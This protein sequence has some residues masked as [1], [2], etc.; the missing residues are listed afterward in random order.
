MATKKW[1]GRKI[2]LL[3]VG[4]A[5]LLCGPKA[6]ELWRSYQET[7]ARLDAKTDEATEKLEDFF[8]DEKEP[9]HPDRPVSDD[10]PKAEP[11][12]KEIIVFSKDWCEPCK[13]W[14]RCEKPRFTALGW[15]VVKSDNPMEPPYPHFVVVDGTT[16]IEVSGYMS[17]EQLESELRR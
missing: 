5:L 17:V 8:L 13:R 12:R 6:A 9:Y 7:Q 11:V 15:S 1:D 2:A 3:A 16:T 10:T 14:E 4:A